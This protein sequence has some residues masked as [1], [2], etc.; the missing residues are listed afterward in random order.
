MTRR[1]R[2]DGAR[3]LRE[4]DAGATLTLSLRRG[5]WD[6]AWDFCA[7]STT[8]EAWSR[9]DRLAKVLGFAIV[10]AGFVEPVAVGPLSLVFALTEA[11]RSAA[12]ASLDPLA[13]PPSKW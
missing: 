9:R 11:G 4:I 6:V 7:L 12:A 3:V 5:S 1:V 8:S 10:D 13:P 2:T